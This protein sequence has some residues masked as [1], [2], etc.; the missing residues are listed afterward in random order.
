MD[1]GGRCAQAVARPATALQYGSILERLNDTFWPTRL[2]DVR[3]SDVSGYV[4]K[5]SGTLA[6]AT[7]GWDMSILHS[8][9]EWAMALEL[10]DRH[11]TRGIAR[12]T[13]RQRKGHALR[14]EEVQ[15]L[16]RSFADDQD[17]VAFLTFVLT[18]MRRSEPKALRWSDVDLSDNNRLRVVDSKTETG[19]RSIALSRRLAEEL[20]RHRQKSAYNR[21][22]D[23][24]FCH[25]ERGTVYRFDT[26]S[27]A[28]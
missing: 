24:V 6:A 21:P 27:A 10:V 20:H 16:A 8:I 12:P 1:R 28:L 4:T 13:V 7:V 18:G 17:R 25:P 3:P 14:P 11:P 5:H 9:S 26:F 19:E 22:G 2:A 23:R 15:A